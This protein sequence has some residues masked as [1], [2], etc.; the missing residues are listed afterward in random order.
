MVVV[1]RCIANERG[2]KGRDDGRFRRR[3]LLW[4]VIRSM[5]VGDRR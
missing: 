5:T 1:E 4:R 3:G 2:K